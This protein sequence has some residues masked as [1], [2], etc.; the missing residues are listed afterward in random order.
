M[1][2]KRLDSCLDFYSFNSNGEKVWIV[3][4]V[5]W[6][7]SHFGLCLLVFSGQKLIQSFWINS[8]ENSDK[9]S[10]FIAT[11]LTN[12]KANAT[13]WTSSEFL[14]PRDLSQG[15]LKTF[16]SFSGPRSIHLVMFTPTMVSREG[17]NGMKC[18]RECV[19][20]FR[21]KFHS[22]KLMN[23]WINAERV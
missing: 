16:P 20:H 18:S 12:P 19:K 9:N 13:H 22:E 14:I 1:K 17:G 2:L 4:G 3:C 23:S 21:F 10:L 11:E 6:M 15:K 5:D 7:L 8:D